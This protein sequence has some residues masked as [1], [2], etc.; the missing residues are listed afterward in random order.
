M[1]DD[2]DQGGMPP[3]M[4]AYGIPPHEVQRMAPDVPS[5]SMYGMVPNPAEMQPQQQQPYQ[6]P[7]PQTPRQKTSGLAI[8]AL[9]LA[10]IVFLP[11]LPLVGAVL[12][13]VAVAK[14]PSGAPGKGLA[15][16]AIPVGCVVTLIH[17]MLAAIAIPAFV[18]YTRLSK[19]TE[20]RE[21]LYK[22]RAGARTYFMNDHYSSSGQLAP[23][24]LPAGSRDWTPS[25]SCCSQG[26]K[27]MPNANEWSAPH[28]KALRFEMSDP[29]YFQY[30]FYSSGTGRS[31]SVV[32][33][34][35]GDLDCD[36]IYSSFKMIGSVD[37]DGSLNIRGPIT[38]RRS[39]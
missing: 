3:A 2:R 16:A 11:I 10:C 6:Q 5:V 18:H 12:G 7:Q 36:G 21:S 29:H 34:A 15:I 35:R 39:E 30:R 8:A 24:R 28:W 33:E 22:L 17:L 9:V 14:L 25:Q 26:G 38:R 1:S 19:T 4:P 13:V 32:I 23:K 31:T 20:A 27:C 37:M